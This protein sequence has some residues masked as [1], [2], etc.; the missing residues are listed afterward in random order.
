MKISVVK[1]AD[2]GFKFGNVLNI[3]DVMGKQLLSLQI[4]NNETF[5]DISNL[6]DGIYFV[7][8]NSGHKNIT[9][10]PQK[11]IIHH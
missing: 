3:T 5:A 9:S 7:R 4:T 1:I 6:S 8:L 10:K 2:D 11:I